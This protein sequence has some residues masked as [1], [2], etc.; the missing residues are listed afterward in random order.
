[1]AIPTK[2]SLVARVVVA[3]VLKVPVATV[4]P[5]ESMVNTAV[6]VAPEESVTYNFLAPTVSPKA[7]IIF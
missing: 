4:F 2:P 3:A 1:M 7:R 6:V 5:S